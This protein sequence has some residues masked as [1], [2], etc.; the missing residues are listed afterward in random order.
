MDFSEPYRYSGPTPAFS[1]DGRFIAVAVEYRLLVR[2]WQT[3]RVVQLFSCLDRIQ[4][5][6]WSPDSMY[7]LCGLY[8]RAIVQ[9]WSV[10]EPEWNCQIDEGQA[11][12]TGVKW[13]PDARRIL[14]MADFQ[15]K[16]TVWSLTD[17]KAVFIKGP[18]YSDKGIA[19]S[20]DGQRLAITEVCVGI[21]G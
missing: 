9:V 12:I 20:P 1:P 15:L 7:I 2:D 13:C 16:A 5:F 14:V 21:G 6:A 10:D 8:D 3:L 18:K 17:R 19:F 4:H 11:G